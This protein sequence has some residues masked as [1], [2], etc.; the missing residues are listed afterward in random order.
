[1]TTE[2]VPAI[3]PRPGRGITLDPERLI[4]QRERH[5]WSRGDMAD[6]VAALARDGHKDALPFRHRRSSE[7]SDGHQA[8][9]A[10]RLSGH[11]RLCM[12]CGNP[13][14]GG[15]TRD[16]FAKIE[17][18]RR[19]P[20]SQTVRAICAALS[21]PDDPVTPGDLKFDGPEPERSAEA[22][23]RDARLEYNRE[24]REF[25]VAIGR[26]ELA[27]NHNGRV[28]YTAELER[29]FGLHLDEE[30]GEAARAEPALAS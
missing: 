25:A 13:V 12:V 26:P 3:R 22:L 24:M 20:K 18:R 7:P 6:R 5:G 19:K 14:T 10:L 8:M 30:A 9:P 1:M 16:A 21:L 11:R 28:R 27:W 17:N 15:I 2:T 29:L 4:W 23:E